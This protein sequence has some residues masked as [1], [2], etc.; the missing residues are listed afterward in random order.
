MIS[1]YNKLSLYGH[2][3]T[4]SPDTLACDCGSRIHGKGLEELSLEELIRLERQIERGRSRLRRAKVRM[5]SLLLSH[6]VF[7]LSP[8]S[9]ELG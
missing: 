7:T 2:E 3:G 1:N 5:C 9:L 4:E 8:Q 6:L